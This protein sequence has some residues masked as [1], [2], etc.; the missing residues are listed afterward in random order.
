MKAMQHK[1]SF[2]IS[3]ATVLLM[4]SA[5]VFGANTHSPK[6]TA[7]PEATVVGSGAP[8]T[9][10]KTIHVQTTTTTTTTTA[11]AEPG[12][13]P[14]TEESK[15]AKEDFKQRVYNE[16]ADIESKI[17]ALKPVSALVVLKYAS[18]VAAIPASFH[19]R[20]SL[21]KTGPLES[22]VARWASLLPHVAS[23]V[24]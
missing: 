9:A 17:A 21:M 23:N 13:A 1:T 22:P 3:A 11:P 24:A 2:D 18:T 15:K 6:S 5:T 7:V 20:P 10:T 12:A 8:K 16:L 14:T 4:M 19:P